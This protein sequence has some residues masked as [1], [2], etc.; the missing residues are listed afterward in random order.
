[1]RGWR[2]VE[3]LLIG[4]ALLPV[5]NPSSPQPTFRATTTL[6]QID[7]VAVDADGHPVPGLTPSDFTLVEGTT[8]REIATFEEFSRADGFAL[9]TFPP[10]FRLD[11]A[12]NASVRMD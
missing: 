7:V 5:Q 12:D 6:V 4:A 8:E 11:V 3:L 2:A 9:P 1:M 10:S